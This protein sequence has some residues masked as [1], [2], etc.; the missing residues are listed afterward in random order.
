ME[1]SLFNFQKQLNELYQ[2][3]ETIQFSMLMILNDHFRRYSSKEIN[4]NVDHC[5]MTVHDAIHYQRIPNAHN[6]I[7]KSH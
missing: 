5:L 7:N 4:L 1:N 3:L 6:D 2:I